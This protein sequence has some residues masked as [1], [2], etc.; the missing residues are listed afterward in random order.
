M[1]KT[2]NS[3]DD[4]LSRSRKRTAKL[5]NYYTYTKILS[6]TFRYVILIGLSF[7]IIFPF[8]SNICTVFMSESDLYDTMVRFIPKD[9]TLENILFMVKKT[10][11]FQVLG[12]TVLLCTMCGLLQSFFCS[13]VGYGL[14]AFR[15]K[16]RGAVFALVM[17]TMLI[18]NT[19]ILSALYQSF[20]NF[21]IFGILQLTTGSPVRLVDS[22]WPMV[23]LSVTCLALKNS[24]YIF[25]FRQYYLNVPPALAEAAKVDGAGTIRT[26]FRIVWPMA[27]NMSLTV[28]LLAFAWQWT[29]TVY[30]TMFFQN[31]FT[32]LS[33]IASTASNLVMDGINPHTVL[34]SCMTNTAL[35]IIVL[36]LLLFFLLAQRFLVQGIEHSGLV[37]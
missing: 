34:A 27:G 10:N 6:A 12:N 16:G 21:D 22:I 4:K 15:F 1:T 19:T 25:V 26:Y 35:F 13:W 5:K 23:I 20:R 30:S 36:P 14:A 29:D 32:V 31:K 3:Q 33:N 2:K 7:V 17:L 8:F 37:G 11:Y 28:F 9:P 24:L 18:P